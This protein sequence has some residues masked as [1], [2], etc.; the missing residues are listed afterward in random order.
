MAAAHETAP[1]LV[2]P[3]AYPRFD[4]SHARSLLREMSTTPGRLRAVGVALTVGL[5]LLGAVGIAALHDRRAAAVA[6]ADVAKPSLVH[7]AN[8]YV[9]LSDG[10]ATASPAFARRGIEPADQRT[11]LQDIDN[12]TAELAALSETA[13]QTP[14]I[15]TD[16]QIISAHLARYT[17]LVETARSNN[18]QGYPVGAAYL[19]AAS[20]DLRGTVLPAVLD[21]YKAEANRL[22]RAYDAGT[23]RQALW[24]VVIVGGLLLALFVTAQIWLARRTHRVVNLALVVATLVAMGLTLLPGVLLAQR[25]DNLNGARRDGS[26]ALMVLS[27]TRILAMRMRADEILDLAGRGT[28]RQAYVDDFDGVKARLQGADNRG[29]LLALAPDGLRAKLAMYIV[30]RERVLTFENAGNFSKAVEEAT[31][32]VGTP[33]PEARLFDALIHDLQVQFDASAAQFSRKIRAARADL[34]PTYAAVAIA[35]IVGAALV[36]AGVHQRLKEY[37]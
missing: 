4:R 5:L 1:T 13:E 16:L 25:T 22:E 19:R 11:Y 35:L 2:N 14:A 18:R 24:T 3:K 17:G 8:L 6:V 30:A 7:A 28:N 23:S 9:A 26:D 31:V 27:S 12:A 34:G 29:G 37:R 21:I 33:A 32:T 10:D 20:D 36:A 15:R